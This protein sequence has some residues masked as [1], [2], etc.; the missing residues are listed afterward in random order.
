MVSSRIY[1]V[2][3]RFQRMKNM[4]IFHILDET[5]IESRIT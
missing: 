2:G 1:M 5:C 4:G 3:F